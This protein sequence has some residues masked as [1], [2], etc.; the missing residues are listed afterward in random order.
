MALT[1]VDLSL[2]SKRIAAPTLDH[3]LILS[4][5]A[6][7]VGSRAG[8]ASLEVIKNFIGGGGVT[9]SSSAPTSPSAGNLWWDTSGNPEAGLKI[10]IGISWLLVVTGIPTLPRRGH[11]GPS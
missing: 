8:V 10:R 11:A 7:A 6:L 4:N 1:A 5:T 3:D 2:P 9:V